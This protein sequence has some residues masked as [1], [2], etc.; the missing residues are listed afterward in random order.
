MRTELKE[1]RKK[2]MRNHAAKALRNPQFRPRVVKP[3]EKEKP[4]RDILKELE[5]EEDMDGV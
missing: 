4:L 1:K 2:R 5:A 3:R